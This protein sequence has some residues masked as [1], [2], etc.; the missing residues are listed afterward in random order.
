[1]N[2]TNEQHQR[3]SLIPWRVLGW[4][5]A[6][7]LILTPLV[8]MQFT[9]EVKW[10][11]TDFIVATI[12]FGIVGGLIELAVRLSSNW[13]FRIGAMFAVLA[14]FM[15]V[16]ANLAV[17]LIGNEDNPVNLWFGTVLFVAIA[18]SIASRFRKRIL[19]F[20][21]FL[22]GAL[23]V[24]IGIFVGILGSDMRGGTFTIVLSVAWFIAS[25]FFWYARQ[26]RKVED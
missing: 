24:A 18:G 4:G 2:I 16:W 17:G 23:Q 11:E 8:A 13:Y 20:A 22:S 25:L 5:A 26:K 7:A 15:V 14:G 19:P 1:M 6:I 3:R 21:M 10:D 9:R 12:I